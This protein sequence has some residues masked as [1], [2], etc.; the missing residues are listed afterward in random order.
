MSSVEM[1]Q[2]LI[3]I[4][5]NFVVELIITIMNIIE[6]RDYIHNHLHQLNERFV[7]EMFDKIR[8]SLEN[9]NQIELSEE[10]KTALEKGVKSLEEGKSSSHE[11]V[12]SRMKK[13]YPNLIK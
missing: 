13:K 7:N 2:Q 3:K 6:K 8:F 1:M 5:R 9:K 12:M 11:E 4:N 10:L